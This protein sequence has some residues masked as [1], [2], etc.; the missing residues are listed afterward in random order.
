[1]T[2][3]APS[4][5]SPYAHDFLRVAVCVPRIEPALPAFN[6]ART[7]ELLRQAHDRK[8]GLMV[9]PELGLSAYAVDDLLFQT[10]LLD[11]VEVEIGHLIEASRDLYPVFAGAS[12]AWSPRCS[13]P[14]IA[15]STSA[16][17]SP[18]ARA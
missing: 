13:C 12:W 15:N 1:M 5:F 8:V 3:P 2:R 4:F 17:G 11:A 14:I 18:A 9:F 10:A 16:G 7:L 6:G